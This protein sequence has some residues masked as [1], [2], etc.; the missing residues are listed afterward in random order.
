MDW[1]TPKSLKEQ[2][3]RLWDRGELLRE[4]DDNTNRFPLRLMLKSPSSSEL[5]D[6]FDQVRQWITELVAMPAIRIEWREVNHRI[7]GKQK[8]PHMVWLDSL[9]L[10]STLIAKQAEVKRYVTLIQLT[11]QQQACALPWLHQYPLRALELSTSWPQLLD[12]VNWLQQHPRPGIYLRQIDLPGI[13][14]KF[15]EIHRS[16]LAELFDLTLPTDAIDSQ[17]AGLSQF[18]ARYGFLDKPMRIRFRILDSKLN[19]FVNTK[20]PDISLDADSFSKLRLPIKRVFI[21]E[22]EINFLSFPLYPEAIVIFGAGYGWDALA[23]ASWLQHCELHYWG[24]IDTHGFAILNQL[25]HY[26]P[27]VRSL[28]MDA[29][30]LHQHQVHWGFEPKPTQHDLLLLTAEEQS[31]YTQLRDHSLQDN[32]RL[33]QE[34]IAFSWVQSALDRLTPDS[35][36]DQSTSK[37]S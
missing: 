30:T 4:L 10:A 9:E 11:R 18:A 7:L 26:F 8:I 24:D 22:N 29:N 14:S 5:A 20:H 6:K 25:R 37:S 13:H 16:V 23:R 3:K 15:I 33:E 2:V 19:V 27:H 28:L 36:V 12:V 32:L 34:F 1:S 31:I 17:K 21:T 35:I